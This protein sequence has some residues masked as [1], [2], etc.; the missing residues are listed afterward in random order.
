MVEP[1]AK[2]RASLPVASHGPADYSKRTTYADYHLAHIALCF[3]V[4]TPAS[5]HVVWE[6]GYLRQMMDIE[7]TQLAVQ[8]KYLQIKDQVMEFLDI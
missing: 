1:V 5:R 7:F 2:V 3:G 8:E 6:Q 4:Q